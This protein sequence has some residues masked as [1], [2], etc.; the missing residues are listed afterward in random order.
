[1]VGC[2]TLKLS[3]NNSN[4]CGSLQLI[5]S[6]V[7]KNIWQYWLAFS[8]AWQRVKN[9]FLPSAENVAVPSYATVLVSLLK[10]TGFANVPEDVF[11]AIKRSPNFSPVQPFMASPSAAGREEVKSNFPLKIAGEKSLYV[12]LIFSRL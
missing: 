1:M 11:P 8:A 5:P 6:K 2:P 12:E 3:G 4:R 7:E 9:I 10:G